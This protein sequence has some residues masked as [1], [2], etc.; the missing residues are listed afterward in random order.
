MSRL[1][2]GLLLLAGP[3]C[4]YR[5]AAGG[6]DLPEAFPRAIQVVTPRNR[7]AE[8]EAGAM[9]A[10]ALGEALDERGVDVT[11]GGGATLSGSIERLSDSPLTFP[12][13]GGEIRVGEYNLVLGV[14]V[15][16]AGTDGTE[17]GRARVV[18]TEPFLSGATMDGTEANRRVA[19]RRVARTL[20]RQL[21]DALALGLSP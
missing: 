20:A 7:T 6:R 11:A 17:L 14:E 12:S 4:A 5:F 1:I 15:R 18:A 13:P 19:L 10:R 2:L 21:V 16:L 9:V 3:G 8:P